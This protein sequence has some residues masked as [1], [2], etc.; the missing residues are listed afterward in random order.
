MRETSLNVSP[1]MTA[2]I[3]VQADVIPFL[4]DSH[5]PRTKLAELEK[6]LQDVFDAGEKMR[7]RGPKRGH[8][9]RPRRRTAVEIMTQA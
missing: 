8:G 2:L 3:E 1:Q 5:Y 6:M 4:R 7:G 9:G